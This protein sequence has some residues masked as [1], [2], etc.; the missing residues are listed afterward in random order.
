MSENSLSPAG[1]GSTRSVLVLSGHRIEVIRGNT[2]LMGLRVG[3]EYAT[4]S[5]S[6]A[7]ALA[8]DLLAA[9]DEAAEHGEVRT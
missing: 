7:R 1:V 6:D 3:R 5:P 8:S 2:W 4:L 9:A